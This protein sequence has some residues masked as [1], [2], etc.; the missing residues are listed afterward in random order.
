[1]QRATG[2]EIETVDKDGGYIGTLW[3][4]K[5]GNAT[6]ALVQEGPVTVHSY[7][8]DTSSSEAV[9]CYRGMS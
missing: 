3:L 7:S 8:A 6:V 2:I 5:N 9:V 1:M 4:N